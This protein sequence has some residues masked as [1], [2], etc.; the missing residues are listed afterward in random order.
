M[1]NKCPLLPRG[2]STLEQMSDDA[3]LDPSHPISTWLC[4]Y[5]LHVLNRMEVSKERPPTKDAKANMLKFSASVRGE[6]LVAAVAGSAST[7]QV[8]R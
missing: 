3:E 8:E 4:E 5:R 7:E 6:N 2:V 1:V